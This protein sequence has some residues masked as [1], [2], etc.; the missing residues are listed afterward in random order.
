MLVAAALIGIGTR[1]PTAALGG[2]IAGATNIEQAVFLLVAL[3]L[4]V[5]ALGKKDLVRPVVAL[6][7]AF[8]ARAVV[9]AWYL[10]NDV[11]V[12]T[13][14]ELFQ[15]RVPR[16]V[17]GFLRNWPLQIFTWYSAAWIIVL[18]LIFYWRRSNLQ[19]ALMAAGLI[20]L[21]A[22]ATITTLDGTRVFVATSS[23]A[24]I[25]AVCNT[26]H[27]GKEGT[28]G[29]RPLTFGALGVMMVTPGLLT[30]VDGVVQNPWA[31]TLSRIADVLGM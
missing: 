15:D 19:R 4:V 21:P 26:A 28:D 2:A 27:G 6:V 22:L 14:G 25:Y 18:A 7:G 24:F 30:W 10:M 16:A 20:L 31:G 5:V 29:L 3:A 13:R 17:A 8:L 9:Q 12:V 1:W 23:A 11:E